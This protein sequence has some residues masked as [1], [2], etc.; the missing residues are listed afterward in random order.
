MHMEE[1]I[2]ELDQVAYAAARLEA[3]IS[4]AP[5]V[6][7]W[8]KEPLTTIQYASKESFKKYLFSEI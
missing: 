5:Y 7:L 3:G 6:P 1:T 4:S 8:F 2:I